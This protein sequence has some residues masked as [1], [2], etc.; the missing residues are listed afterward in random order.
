M[1]LHADAL[2][3]SAPPVNSSKPLR[4]RRSQNIAR[5]RLP[6]SRAIPSTWANDR[7]TCLVQIYGF[8][9]N[10]DYEVDKNA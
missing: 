7:T 4:E 3:D 8:G 9:D 6:P 10:V 1:A 5:A 2:P